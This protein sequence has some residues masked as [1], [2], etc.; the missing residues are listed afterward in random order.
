MSKPSDNSVSIPGLDFE[1]S[2]EAFLAPLD[3]YP[4]V[5]V[6]VKDKDSRYVYANKAY[7]DMLKTTPEAM[8]GKSDFDLYDHRFAVLYLAEDRA[9]LAGT[10]FINQRWMVPDGGGVISWCVAHKFPLRNRDGTI[11]GIICTFRDLHMA[12]IEAKPFFDLAE[13]VQ[14]MHDHFANEITAAQLAGVIGLSVSQLNRKFTDTMGT[15]PIRYLVK[16]RADKAAE[17]LVNTDKTINE[18]CFA[19]GFNSQ[20]YFNR[21]FK[22]HTDL[23]PKQY[24][25][26]YGQKKQ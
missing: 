4:D 2:I 13:V 22:R 19:C 3:H 25:H 5:R 24:R 11:C 21:Q 20:T 6:F 26:R 23:T 14:F 12:G 9:A 16:L 8:I 1:N 10:D 15:S 17:L 18:I 7:A